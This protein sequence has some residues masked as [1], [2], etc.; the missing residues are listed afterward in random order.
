MI[1]SPFHYE[2]WLT[3]AE[4]QKL[5]TLS[6]RWSHIEHI[7]GNCLR[8][9]L[10][11]DEKEAVVVVFPMPIERRISMIRD[12]SK[13]NPLPD[14]TTHA[15]NEVDWGLDYVRFVRNTLAHTVMSENL[16][17][18]AVFNLRSKNRSL[19]KEQV[20]AVEEITNYTAHAALHFRFLL[21]FKELTHELQPLPDRPVIPPI[22]QSARQAPKTQKP[23][24]PGPLI[25]PE[26]GRQ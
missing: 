24:L 10:R 4:L 1:E 18:G 7:I 12:I 19:T 14:D 9:I 8:V 16:E 21:G 25:K 26:G 17:Q 15:F 22:L 5:A 20:F 13:I 2:E 11:L 3:P 6:L 23:A